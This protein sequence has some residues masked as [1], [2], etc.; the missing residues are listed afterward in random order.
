MGHFSITFEKNSYWRKCCL[1]C[2]IS[3]LVCAS[4]REVCE[5]GQTGDA[6]AALPESRTGAARHQP[7]SVRHPEHHRV[8]TALLPGFTALLIW[9]HSELRIEFLLHTWNDSSELLLQLCC[10]YLF[11]CFI[12]W[13]KQ[14]SFV[15][16]CWLLCEVLL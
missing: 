3:G 8:F 12:L 13:W 16:E 5:T 4:G 11:Y 14:A 7:A 1:M 2:V 10:N 9:K 15:T 6:P